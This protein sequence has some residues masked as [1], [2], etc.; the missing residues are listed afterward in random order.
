[1]LVL[2]R[3]RGEAVIVGDDVAI[4]VLA[5]Q[6][7]QVRIGVSAPRSVSVHREEIYLRIAAEREDREQSVELA[8]V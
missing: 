7:N 1:M 3:K 5:I 6:G 2:S 8:E 4:T